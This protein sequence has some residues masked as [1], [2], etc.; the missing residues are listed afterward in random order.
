[1]A[2]CDD[3]HCRGTSGTVETG[4]DMESDLHQR[5]IYYSDFVKSYIHLFDLLEESSGGWKFSFYSVGKKTFK[6]QS[7]IQSFILKYTY[8][9]LSHVL[10]IGEIVK[11]DA[12]YEKSV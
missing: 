10:E 8:K 7:K 6:T 1:M 9:F 2:L 11:S 12:T 4:E 5:S 3:S